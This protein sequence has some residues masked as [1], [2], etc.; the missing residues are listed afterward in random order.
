MDVASESKDFVGLIYLHLCPI[1]FPFVPN[2]MSY[3]HLYTKISHR[4]ILVV[5]YLIFHFGFVLCII[6]NV[7][8][9]VA[10]VDRCDSHEEGYFEL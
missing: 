3:T 7:Y 8:E 4:G 10:A 6:E 9:D 2:I 5:P 1:F